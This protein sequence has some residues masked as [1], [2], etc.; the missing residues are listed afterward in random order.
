MVN[1]RINF[2]DGKKMKGMRKWLGLGMVLL[3]G[4]LV[5]WLGCGQRTERTTGGIK[6]IYRNKALG[7]TGVS[8]ADSLSIGF[9]SPIESGNFTLSNNIFISYGS[10]HTAGT[11][12]LSS[13][14][15]TFSSDKRMIMVS[16]IKSWSKLTN[17]AGLPFPHC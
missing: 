16:G 12:E 11:P 2:K 13:A 8:T 15:L 17:G 6:V 7:A 1:L 5:L 14:T 9:D 10:S 4:S 3:A